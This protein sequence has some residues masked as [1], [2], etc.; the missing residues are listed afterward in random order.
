MGRVVIRGAAPGMWGVPCFRPQPAGRGESLN[1]WAQ[2]VLPVPGS[3]GTTAAGTQ[4]RGRALQ[5]LERLA[6]G[7]GWRGESPGGP[8]VVSS[9]WVAPGTARKV[10]PPLPGAPP[11]KCSSSLQVPTGEVELPT[12]PV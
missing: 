12:H 7:W 10:A 2:H 3:P 5:G 4:A 1:V 6:W 9:L 11:P 8:F